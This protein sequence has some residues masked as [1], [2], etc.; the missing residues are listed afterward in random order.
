M[1]L[2]PPKGWGS[3]GGGGLSRATLT[4]V[5]GGGG[6]RCIIGREPGGG[7]PRYGGRIPGG[8]GPRVMGLWWVGGG[9]MGGGR[10]WGGRGAGLGVGRLWTASDRPE[11]GNCW[12]LTAFLV[13]L[14]R[15]WSELDIVDPPPDDTGIGGLP[16]SFV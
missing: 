10:M 6:P 14:I 16:I 9:R 1:F 4:T 3:L 11:S 12:L 7:T 15:L 5:P 8:G 13:V 2:G